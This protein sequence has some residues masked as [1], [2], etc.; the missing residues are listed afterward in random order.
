MLLQIIS[1]EYL[2]EQNWC[3]CVCARARARMCAYVCVACR[4]LR[5]PPD[6][7]GYPSM[8]RRLGYVSPVPIYP[9]VLSHTSPNS[10]TKR[11]SH[12]VL[13]PRTMHVH[14][15]LASLTQSDRCPLAFV[16]R[17]RRLFLSNNSNFLNLVN[18]SRRTLVRALVMRTYKRHVSLVIGVGSG[19]V[20]VSLTHVFLSSVS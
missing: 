10:S 7:V 15:S 13:C 12:Q 1:E 8:E 17:I 18:R 3:V 5:S 9:E 14:R 19:V 6:L 20:P 11:I 2:Q 4:V 16:P